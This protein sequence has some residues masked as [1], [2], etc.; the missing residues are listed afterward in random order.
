MDCGSPMVAIVDVGTNAMHLVI[1][2]VEPHRQFH[3]ELE[4]HDAARLGDGGLANG[5]LTAAAMR[6]GMAVLSRYAALLKRRRIDA[7]EAVATSAVREAAN[8]PAFVRRV[9]ARL[10][11]PLRIISGREEARLIYRGVARAQR[12]RRAALVIAIGGGSAQVM[13]GDGRRLRYAVSR[14]L[15][16]VRLTQQFIHHDPPRPEEVEALTWHVRRAWAPVARVIRRAHPRIAWGSSTAIRQ[17]IRVA[18]RTDRPRSASISQ[19]QVRGLIARLSASTAQERLRWPGMDPQRHAMLLAAG[20]ALLAW[21]E[22]CGV[23]TVRYAVGS[24]REGLVMEHLSRA[25]VRQ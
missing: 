24:L 15:G 17:L 16:C 10:G 6:R 1:G 19:R 18:G 9:R 21:M 13:R 11:L 4:R 7:V 14:P 23:S 12:I 3:V 2:R 22:G 8:G 5:A 25:G 20:V